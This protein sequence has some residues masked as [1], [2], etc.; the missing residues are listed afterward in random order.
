MENPA[1]NRR[2]N[3]LTQAL[4]VLGVLCFIAIGIGLW[5]WQYGAFA[6]IACFLLAPVVR[7]M[8]LTQK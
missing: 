7:Q 1:D 2:A 6:G 3:A 8:L 5:R 4:R